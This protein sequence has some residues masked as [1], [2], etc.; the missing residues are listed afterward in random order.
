MF[1]VNSTDAGAHM[2]SVSTLLFP[3]LVSVLSRYAAVMFS[4]GITY[5][6]LIHMFSTGGRLCAFANIEK[7]NRHYL[8]FIEDATLALVKG[9][10]KYLGNMQ[11]PC[12]LV[13]MI[14]SLLFSMTSA[15]KILIWLQRRRDVSTI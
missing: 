15:C 2:S 5:N 4:L 12:A 13:F 10:L 14:G 1:S 3:D 11:Y 8:F 9:Q 7:T 6:I